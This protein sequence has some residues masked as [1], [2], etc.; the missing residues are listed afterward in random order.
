MD[1]RNH[2]LGFSTG[3]PQHPH[4]PHHHQP[5]PPPPSAGSANQHGPHGA[6]RFPGD[7]PLTAAHRR[8]A[9]L[10]GTTMAAVAQVAL[11]SHP[12]PRQPPPPLP[13]RRF[14][15]L[16]Q[17]SWEAQQA[18]LQSLRASFTT[19]AALEQALFTLVDWARNA[20]YFK[21]V[22]VEDQMQLLNSSW[23]EILLLEYLYHCVHDNR[24]DS[25]ES[26]W[27]NHS[28]DI[29][30]LLDLS[31][32]RLMDLIERVQSLRLDKC[33]FAALKT[34]AGARAASFEAKTFT[35]RHAAVHLIPSTT[36]C[37]RASLLPRDR[38]ALRPAGPA[39]A[40]AGWAEP[41]L[42]LQLSRRLLQRLLD[43]LADQ[44]AATSAAADAALTATST[45][46]R[47]PTTCETI[48]LAGRTA[49]TPPPTEPLTM[50]QRWRRITQGRR[51]R[52]FGTFENSGRIGSIGSA[53]VRERR[54]RQRQQ[55][56][57]CGRAS[58]Q[59]HLGSERQC[60]QFLKLPPH[61]IGRPRMQRP[62]LRYKDSYLAF[63]QSKSVIDSVDDSG[64]W[65]PFL[66]DSA[67][68]RRPHCDGLRLVVGGDA[69]LVRSF[70][71]CGVLWASRQVYAEVRRLACQAGARARGRL[72]RRVTLAPSKL[73][74]GAAALLAVE[75]IP[76]MA[77]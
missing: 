59:R 56:A 39:S 25:I 12:P 67:L 64:P 46:A 52:H 43:R 27:L 32:L 66:I 8:L 51:G 72:L 62:T 36:A 58:E 11:P 17:Q 63:F 37:R 19:C 2:M 54:Q 34:F 68:G 16:S 41:A 50:G 48:H 9:R 30:D 28:A 35:E 23:G 13:R 55:R 77:F 76:A 75:P 45:S 69:S 31:E 3:P 14:P 15:R 61:A 74:N 22:S 38:A 6:L 40:P 71:S 57:C 26:S 18:A 4:P 1:N 42:A 7:V 20:D 5:Q 44:E 70:G 10:A 33:E 29:L 49:P 47:L 73:A 53:R 21:V 60:K 24:K 65:P